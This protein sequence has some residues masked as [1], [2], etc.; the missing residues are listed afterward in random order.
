[1]FARTH[2]EYVCVMVGNVEKCCDI[3]VRVPQHLAKEIRLIG[4]DNISD[5]SD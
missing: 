4:S 5:I 1:M 3:S 2:S